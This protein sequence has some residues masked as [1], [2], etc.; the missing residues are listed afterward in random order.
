[1]LHECLLSER[2]A[3]RARTWRKLDG[4][5]RGDCG[6]HKDKGG[7]DSDEVENKEEREGR[8]GENK[9]KAMMRRK[10]RRC[11]EDDEETDKHEGSHS[12]T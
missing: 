1:M 12:P 8:V 4:G 9:Y 3:K 7:E 11:I 10:L 6:S 5:K 2:N